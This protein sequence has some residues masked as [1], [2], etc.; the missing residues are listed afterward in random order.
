ML[1]ATKR[2]IN[3]DKYSLSNDL[4]F[5]FQCLNNTV[6]DTLD[7]PASVWEYA[8]LSFLGSPGMRLSNVMS[9]AEEADI[10]ALQQTLFKDG[11]RF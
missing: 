3:T 11:L 8:S 5:E 6:L 1:A 7:I 4:P 10:N 9:M 2:Y